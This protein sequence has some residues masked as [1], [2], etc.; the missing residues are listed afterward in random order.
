MDWAHKCYEAAFRLC[1]AARRKTWRIAHA[2]V[3]GPGG[4]LGHAWVESRTKVFDLTMPAMGQPDTWDRFDY[5]CR[6]PIHRV[7][8]YNLFQAV[9][10]LKETGTFGAWADFLKKPGLHLN[11]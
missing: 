8:R 3:E 1:W 6:W 11:S 4:P 9:Y 10:L 7:Q 5:Y 2:L